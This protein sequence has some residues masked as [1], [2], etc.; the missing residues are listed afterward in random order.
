YIIIFSPGN[1]P[2][3][4]EKT[5]D[6]IM[7]DPLNKY[8]ITRDGETDP[9]VNVQSALDGNGNGSGS[10]TLTAGTYTVTIIFGDDAVETTI[11]VPSSENLRS[12]NKKIS[13]DAAKKRAPSKISKAPT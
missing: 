10:R 4:C 12:P 8:I 7:S 11:T 1:A 13:L 6:F 9:V 3:H 2:H 5:L